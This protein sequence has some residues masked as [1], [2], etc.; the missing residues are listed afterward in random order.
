[1]IDHVSVAVRDLAAGSR[2]YEVLLATLGYT[3]MIARATTV[4]FGKQYPDFWINLQARCDL[5]A[6]DR[7]LRRR[8]EREVS[9]RAA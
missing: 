8:I 6:A 9:P 4:G 1:M 7:K 2:F 3:K 5:E